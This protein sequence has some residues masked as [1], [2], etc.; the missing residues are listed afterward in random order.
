LQIFSINILVPFAVGFFHILLLDPQISESML[1][2]CGVEN[3]FVVLQNVIV[4]Q[5]S[6]K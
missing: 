4:G 3:K 5:V 1:I 2:S 6:R